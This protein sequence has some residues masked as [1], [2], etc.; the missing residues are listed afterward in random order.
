MIRMPIGM[1]TF[2]LLVSPLVADAQEPKR[3]ASVVKAWYTPAELL[4]ALADR[5]GIRWALPET[6]AGRALVGEAATTDAL[7][8]NACQQWGLAWTRQKDVLVVHRGNEDRLKKLTAALKNGDRAAAWELGWLRDGR[9][10]PP[11]A[12]ALAGKDIALALAA[13]QAIEVLDTMVPLGRDERVDPAPTG[14]VSM[15]VA[16]PPTVKLDGL[17]DSPY[18]PVRAAALRLLLGQGG[19]AAEDAKTRSAD[20][21]SDAVLRV[22]QQMFPTLP[23]S[24]PRNAPLPIPKDAPAIKAACAKMLAEIPDLAKRSEW[25]QMRWRVR[26]MGAWSRANHAAATAA[27]IE[28]SDTKVQQGWFPAYVHMHLAAT[29]SPE[30][31]A[32]LKALF[33][34]VERGT[35]ARGLEQS[36]Y[37]NA[38]LAFTK[39]YLG[40]QTLCYITARKAGREAHDDLLAFAARGN[41]AAI[42]ALGVIGGSE[43]VATLRTQLAKDDDATAIFRSAKAL[44]R[45]GSSEALEALLAASESNER[46]R[47]H[48]A[49]LFLGQLGGLKANARL[50]EMFDKDADRLVRAAAADGLEQIGVKDSQAVVAAFRKADAGLPQ[51]VHQPRNPRFGPDFPVNKW[52]NLKISIKADSPFGEMG[53]N[54]D[55][56]NRLFLRYGGCSGY[57]NELTVFDLGTEQFIQRRPNEKMAGWGDRRLINGCTAGRCWDPISKVM[58]LGPAIGSTEPSLAVYDYYNKD[59]AFRFCNYDLA[60]DR[61]RAAPKATYATRYAFDWKNGLLLPVKFTHVNHKTKDFWAFDVKSSTWLDKKTAGDYPRDQDHTNAAFDHDSGLLVLYVAPHPDRPAETWTYDPVRNVWKN[62]QPK[63]QPAGV[64]GGGFVY[65]PFHKLLLLQSGKVATQYGGGDDSITWTYDVRTNTWTDL[66]VKT[67]PG[68]PWVGAMDYDPEHNVFVLFN[69]RD[70]NVWAYRYKAVTAGAK[71]VA[72]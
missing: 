16:Y 68:N 9:V 59:G 65:D 55:V 13:A 43:A 30:A 5:D 4:T 15:A 66:N 12:D 20:D 28:L 7:L 2:A 32:K 25:E 57:H 34:K 3:D 71:V 6:L 50:R 64:S 10:L 41:L 27:L 38:L 19:K 23:E 29:G 49:A 60:T 58:W 56:S 62:M 36:M 40:E 46:V 51:I 52:V 61:F 72:G 26:T 11:L 48:A 24:K 69:F 17:L 33:P 63:T 54:Y 1:V 47:R 42:D 31:V 70:R 22:R 14:R 18:P 44:A 45:I 53:W 37:G 8:D 21:R 39:P 67:G 35:P